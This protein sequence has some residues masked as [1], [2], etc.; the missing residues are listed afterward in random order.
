MP[1]L[2]WRWLPPLDPASDRRTLPRLRYLIEIDVDWHGERADEA[3]RCGGDVE[4]VHARSSFNRVLAREYRDRAFSARRPRSE[5]ASATPKPSQTM[6]RT[7]S[8]SSSLS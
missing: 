8:R 3:H 4:L 6:S 1:A 7:S 5:P 2:L